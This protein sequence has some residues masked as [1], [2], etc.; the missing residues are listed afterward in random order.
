MS[1]KILVVDDSLTIQKVVNITLANTGY[2]LTSA[3]DE[4]ELFN[5]LEKD[6]YDL[7]LLDFNLSE[8]LT[9][10]EL[11]AKIKE[12]N[13]KSKILVMIGTFDNV[14]D[15]ELQEAGIAESIIKPFESSKF[16]NLCKS[17]VESIEGNSTDTSDDVFE[18]N[19][20]EDEDWKVS[21][22]SGEDTDTT[23][24]AEEE[25]EASKDVALDKESVNPNSLKD[26][27]LGWGISL[28]EI[29][30]A[31]EITR[32][33]PTV[34]GVMP[35]KIDNSEDIEFRVD[36]SDQEDED[37]VDD[38]NSLGLQVEDDDLL[39]PE[40][41]EEGSVSSK[42]VSVDELKLEKDEVGFKVDDFLQDNELVEE[43]NEESDDFWAI[44]DEEEEVN[45]I[46]PKLEDINESKHSNLSIDEIVSKVKEELK[47][48]LRV[49]IGDIIEEKIKEVSTEVVERVAWEAIPELAESLIQSEIKALS[50]KVQDKHSS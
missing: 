49:M 9:G 17:L 42:L 21:I 24:E 39:F 19:G 43:V 50:E 13:D 48:E 6:K 27:I 16:T 34:D 20:D 26:E 47:E 12:N 3:H 25:I 33:M 4:D 36:F 45:E 30:E 14:N 7:I 29:I 32:D 11:V 37:F 31:A 5:K 46:G 38:E 35:P 8:E 22:G 28:P 1:A 15:S 18:D 2:V 23:L 10:Y 41:L 44:D 40:V